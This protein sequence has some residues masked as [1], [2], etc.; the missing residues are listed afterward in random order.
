MN[1]LERL[2]RGAGAQIGPPE[3]SAQEMDGGA[4]PTDSN[5]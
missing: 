1:R 5:D 4:Q 3:N 2:I